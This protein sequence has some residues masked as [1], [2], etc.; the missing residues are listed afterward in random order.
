MKEEEENESDIYNQAGFVELSRYTPSPFI[1]ASP[2]LAFTSAFCSL[3][4][5]CS[6]CS[7][8][9][10]LNGELWPLF[11]CAPATTCFL[12]SFFFPFGVLFTVSFR[13]AASPSCDQRPNQFTPIFIFPFVFCATLLFFFWNDLI[14]IFAIIYI[15]F[16]FV[17]F[18][19]SWVFDCVSFFSRSPFAPLCAL[20]HLHLRIHGDVY[21]RF[22]AGF[23]AHASHVLSRRWLTFSR[24]VFS[25]PSDLFWFLCYYYSCQIMRAKSFHI[26]P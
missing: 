17:H 21:F 23:G 19:L 16:P 15:R 22:L 24:W 10:S 3:S 7:A 25:K 1:V 18:H 20:Q 9:T 2:P 6:F 11:T 26:C 12:L 13:R 14:K 5:Y 4:I 8:H